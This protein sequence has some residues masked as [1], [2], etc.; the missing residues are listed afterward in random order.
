MLDIYCDLTLQCATFG[1]HIE[2]LEVEELAS[3]RRSVTHD[4]IATKLREIRQKMDVQPDCLDEELAH[5]A[6][7]SVALDRL[8][9]KHRLGS[10]AYYYQGTGNTENEDV[11][12]SI[13]LGNSLLT[14]RG[15]PVAGEYE[16]KNAQAMK[17]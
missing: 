15:I 10:L 11:V 2:I 4:E 17:I 9:E 14:A 13:I 6:K 5:A 3:I 1:G 12:S 8:V 16:V 7:T